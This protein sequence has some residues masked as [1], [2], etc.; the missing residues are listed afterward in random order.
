MGYKDG[1][2]TA[3]ALGRYKSLSISLA[4][5]I[6]H[7]VD[8][9]AT[10]DQARRGACWICKKL[11]THEICKDIPFSEVLNNQKMHSAEVIG[12]LNDYYKSV[13]KESNSKISL[14]L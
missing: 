5:S 12:R 13:L 9:V 6:K 3:F 7:P 2:E 8:I 10:L 4:S 11:Q 1:F 14:N